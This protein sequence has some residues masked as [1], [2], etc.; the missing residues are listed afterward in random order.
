MLPFFT[1][2]Q[3]EPMRSAR[4]VSILVAILL[5]IS[6]A[7]AQN[8]RSFVATTG[9]DTNDCTAGH[10]CRTFTRAISVTNAG[11]EI[12]ALT[13]GGYGSLFINKSVTVTA[14][15]GSASITTSG[16]DA[17]TVSAGS[18]D[19]VALRGLNLILTGPNDVGI[20]APSF[21]TLS[22]ENCSVNGGDIG[23]AVHASATSMATIVDTVVRN[24]DI[25][26]FV[27]SRA[28]L[29]RCRS[30]RNTSDGMLVKTDAVS[31]AIVTATDF[32]ASGNQYGIDVFSGAAG[33][34]AVLNLD[35]A[36]IAHNTSDGVTGS[37]SGT[38]ADAT[39][40]ISNSSVTQ[41]GG[42][43]LRGT[44]CTLQSLNNNL[45]AGNAG[46][47]TTAVINITPH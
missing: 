40:R 33:H 27:Q 8:N 32:V 37:Q 45:V 4:R 14:A 3:G 11:G 16:S 29:L 17:I 41:N 24:A 19:R 26:L 38:I 46:G 2:T 30:E 10:D 39:I 7:Y 47:D 35:R 9:S 13:A 15:N 31:T 21:G 36:T 22:I 18:T 5:S 44:S 28:L 43:G 12:I 23:I 34:P 20:Y 42:M 1:R 25:G 6:S